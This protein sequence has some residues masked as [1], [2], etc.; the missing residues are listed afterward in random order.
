MINIQDE[1]LLKILEK[2]IVIFTCIQ[3]RVCLPTY[4]EATRS[5]YPLM[6]MDVAELMAMVLHLSECASCQQEYKDL[7]LLSE[8]KKRGEGSDPEEV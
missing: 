1:E 8:E 3:C 7:V 6:Q 2:S 5:D 4:Y